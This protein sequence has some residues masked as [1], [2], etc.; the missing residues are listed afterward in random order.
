MNSACLG[1]GENFS[2][3]S[4]LENVQEGTKEKTHLGEQNGLQGYRR[5]RVRDNEVILVH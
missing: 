1:L 4:F 5:V 3:I 2:L